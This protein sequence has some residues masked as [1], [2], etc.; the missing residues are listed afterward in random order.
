MARAQLE[1]GQRDELLRVLVRTEVV[2][3]IADDN[4]ET[5]RVNTRA[6]QMIGARL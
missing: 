5:L 6:D 4:G 2:R 1:D 3:A